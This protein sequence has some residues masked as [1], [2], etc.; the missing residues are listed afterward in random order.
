MD[1]IDNNPPVNHEHDPPGERRRLCSHGEYSRIE[2]G[3]LASTGRQIDDLWPSA[4]IKHL[5]SQ[6]LLPWK[7][8]M[9]MDVSKERSEVPGGQLL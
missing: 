2:H 4:P 7:R 9:A 3:G 5:R 8:L 6:P 1:L